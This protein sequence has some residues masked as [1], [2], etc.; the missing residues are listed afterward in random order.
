MLVSRTEAE[1]EQVATEIES[2][3][4]RASIRPC[5]VTDPGGVDELFRRIKN[6]D[7]LVNS[8]G[9][10][11]PEP[12]LDVTDGNLEL[13]LATNL[14]SVVYTSQGAVRLALEARHDL[15]IVNIS[16]QMGHVG[17]PNRS[18]YCATKHAVEG[19]TKALA[20]ELAPKGIRVNCVAPTF[21]D[22]PLTRPFFENDTFRRDVLASIP[23]GRIA[24]V[25]DVVGAV[26]FVASQAAALVTGT[27]IIVDGGWT[28]R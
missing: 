9:C 8:A 22:T 14:K 3:G 6:V 23:I 15:A 7:V 10:N 18:V 19:L 11:I 2:E 4:G 20:V 24:T 28:A 25:G 16:S 17:A 12:F 5:D 21:V 27:S 13:L 26:L 1:L